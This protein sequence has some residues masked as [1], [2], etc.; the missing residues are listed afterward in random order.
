MLVKVGVKSLQSAA[1]FPYLPAGVLQ[2]REIGIGKVG[3]KIG[4][5]LGSMWNF[6]FVNPDAV[7]FPIHVEVV[8]QN[9]VRV[10]ENRDATVR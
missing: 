10:K 1:I 8:G 2:I 7:L 3:V 5:F 6:A 4:N 9:A